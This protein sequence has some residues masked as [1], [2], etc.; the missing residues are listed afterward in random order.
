MV[1]YSETIYRIAYYG[2]KR[3]AKSSR[4]SKLGAYLLTYYLITLNTYCKGKWFAFIYH[5]IDN[6]KEWTTGR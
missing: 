1:A 5:R 6:S 4:V 3:D 2:A